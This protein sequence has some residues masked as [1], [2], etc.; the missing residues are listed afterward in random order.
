[1]AVTVQL[2]S[3]AAPVRVKRNSKKY[4]SESEGVS[5][6]LITVVTLNLHPW[7]WIVRC[8]NKMR[9]IEYNML[10]C[11]VTSSPLAV[12]SLANRRDW[13]KLKKMVFPR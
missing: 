13:L 4:L 9:T 8:F 10:R 7:S 2:K 5:G 6:R 12:T 3:E 1:M 11:S